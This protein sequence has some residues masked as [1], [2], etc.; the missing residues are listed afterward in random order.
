MIN[1]NIYCYYNQIN[2][3]EAK[4]LTNQSLELLNL[5]KQSWS[6]FGWNPVVLDESNAKKNQRIKKIHFN[7]DSFLFKLDSNL[8]EYSS[9]CIKR[10]FAY[11]SCFIK[12]PENNISCEFNTENNS[13]SISCNT[14]GN[15]NY[16]YNYITWADYD[17]M[18]YGFT[19]N[20]AYSIF[21]SNQFK[22]ARFCGEY[23]CGIMDKEGSEKIIN[24]ILKINNLK[25]VDELKILMPEWKDEFTND[26]IF[27]INLAGFKNINVCESF[28]NKKAWKNSKLLHFH[29]GV[30]HL[31]KEAKNIPTRK[32]LVE[33]LRPIF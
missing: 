3:E 23:A 20:E 8:V 18:N 27:L 11:R 26:M 29:N 12:T 15:S 28:Y 5:W 21:K 32:E 22:S 13:F 31:I 1:N 6:K 25:S 17:V 2:T 19:P 10:W 4:T 30:N 9:Q 16:D 14:N 7:R 33:R 24:T